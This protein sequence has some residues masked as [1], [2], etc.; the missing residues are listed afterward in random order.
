MYINAI[1]T[2][3]GAYYYVYVILNFKLI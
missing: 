1:S 2:I 3:S